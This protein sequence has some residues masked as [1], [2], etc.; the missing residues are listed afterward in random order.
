[1]QDVMS[2]EVW[3]GSLAFSKLRADHVGA[4]RQRWQSGD[5]AVCAKRH[6][7]LHLYRVP[8]HELHLA[9]AQAVILEHVVGDA[10]HFN[11]ELVGVIDTGGDNDT[12]VGGAHFGVIEAHM[13]ALQLGDGVFHL[14]S[15]DGVGE[16]LH[17]LLQC[18]VMEL[19]VSPCYA[20]EQQ[21]AMLVVLILLVGLK[22]YGSLD[23][24]YCVDV[25]RHVAL[26]GR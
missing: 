2:I 4:I 5:D 13:L 16:T 21:C 15:V 1:M 12:V 23:F 20:V 14:S 26:G 7:A 17:I 19:V 6:I 24:F 9:L 3:V 11:S 10:V 18:L 25:C 8:R 22:R